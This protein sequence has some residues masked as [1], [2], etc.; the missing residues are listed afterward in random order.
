MLRVALSLIVVLLAVAS[1][2]A[3]QEPPE[4]GVVVATVP[5]GALRVYDE[6]E[7]LCVD[8]T[9]PADGSSSCSD[10]LDEARFGPIGV[11]TSRPPG[12]DGAP[13]VV[14][15]AVGADVASVRVR[16]RGG[17]APVAAETVAG[18]AYR[19]RFAGKVRFFAVVLPAGARPVDVVVLAADGTVLGAV[20]RFD[21][22]DEPVV[23]PVRVATLG[24]GR[25]RLTLAAQVDE[26]LEPTAVDP[27]R[28]YRYPCFTVRAVPTVVLGPAEDPPLARAC[29]SPARGDAFDVRVACTPSRTVVLGLLDAGAAVPTAVLGSGRRLRARAFDL[30]DQVLPGARGWLVV[31]PGDEA[32]R[33]VTGIGALRYPPAG[34]ACRGEE[35]GAFNVIS[36]LIED[37]GGEAVAPVPAL[38]AAREREG[39][40]L[41]LGDGPEEGLCVTVDDVAP[42]AGACLPLSPRADRRFDAAPRPGGGGQTVGG[43]TTFPGAT[44]AVVLL[45]DGTRVST[46]VGP[47]VGGY[48]G[49]YA[50]KLRT[51][52]VPTASSAPVRRITL[53]DAA[54]RR[55][56][57]D[58]QYE[59]TPVRDLRRLAAVRGGEALWAGTT[60]VQVPEGTG[61]L[62][63][64]C[65]TVGA[66]PR[67]AL[68]CA[69]AD[70]GRF[71]P[72]VS[73]DCAPRRIVVTGLLPKGV[74]RAELVLA[75]RERRSARTY[76]AGGGRRAF[77][78]V[79]GPRDRLRAI[80]GVTRRSRIVR[81]AVLP[82]AA[83]QCGYDA[84]PSLFFG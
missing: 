18:E 58:E 14:A 67:S 37:E 17:A 43:A 74:L 57:A 11:L 73:V 72:Q 50:T 82:P 84:S 4:Q 21:A 76:A 80:H 47:E 60:A 29:R 10:V 35:G 24:S 15:G 23:G 26:E 40:R 81:P 39:A 63:F 54:G 68:D 7:S 25:A 49:P 9:G 12:G 56:T 42:T 77:L 64:P 22:S 65:L 75:G 38:A 20:D 1:P 69:F 28:R 48:A 61:T 78:A 66:R 31:V 51:W 8:L 41:L 27:A 5:G 62:S 2:A 19:G 55:L 16:L 83:A 30:P 59:H 52:L 70:Q 53:L 46:E 13:A 33:S 45:A 34:I 32:L 71:V 36:S 79:L 44:R 6:R 3:A